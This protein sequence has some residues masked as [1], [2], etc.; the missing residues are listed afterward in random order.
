[1][2][3]FT[4]DDTPKKKTTH[5]VGCD[6]SSLSSDELTARIALLQ[7]EITRLEQERTRKNAGRSAAE[8]L[9]KR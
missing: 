8:S 5:E 3:F 6:L 7:T 9:F 1:M 4:D 2:S